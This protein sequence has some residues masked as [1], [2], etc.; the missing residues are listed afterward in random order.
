MCNMLTRDD[1]KS[2]WGLVH[3]G[4]SWLGIEE[5]V[6]AVDLG[7]CREDST[8]VRFGPRGDYSG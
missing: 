8:S 3:S 6:L 1:S 4:V 7:M 2:F 5:T